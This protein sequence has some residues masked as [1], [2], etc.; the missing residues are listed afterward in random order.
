MSLHR[1][2]QSIAP[3]QKKW[4]Q[5]TEKNQSIVPAEFTPKIYFR[6]P[7]V[8]IEKTKLI[9]PKTSVNFKEKFIEGC[10]LVSY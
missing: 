9:A 1:K 2:S 10:V 4:A 3:K 6:D 5:R 7:Q 8:R